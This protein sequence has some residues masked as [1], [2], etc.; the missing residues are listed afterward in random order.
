[1]SARG[2]SKNQGISQYTRLLS[3]PKFDEELYLYLAV[4][5]LSIIFVLVREEPDVEASL[6]YQQDIVEC[7]NLILLP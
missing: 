3:K 7:R 6:L 2:H 5:H 1:M 4:S